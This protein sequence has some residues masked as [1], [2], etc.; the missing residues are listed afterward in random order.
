[1]TD[2][3]KLGALSALASAG[4]LDRR[5]FLLTA[6]AAGLSALAADAMWRKARAAEP[7]AGG[8]LSVGA[9]GGATSDTMSPLVATGADHPTIAALSCYDTL[10]EM[11]AAGTPQPSLAE[12][13]EGSADGTW[14]FRL[15]KGVEFHDGTPLTAA[16]VVWSLAQH[17]D[18]ASKFAEGKQIVGNFE[19][20]RAD[21]PDTVIIR[22]REVNFDLPAHLSS[23]GL[24]VGKEGTQTWDTGIG[25]G[26]YRLEAWEPGV[27]FAGRKFDGFYRDD[28]GH[29]DQ[30]EV[31]NVTD[32]TSRVGGLLSK[33]LDVIGSPP[34]ST[35]ARLASAPGV[36]LT[37]VA[38]TQH[39]TTDMR[40]DMDPFTSA[41]LRN[42]VKWGVKRDEI[43]QKVLGGYGTV[44]NDIPISRNQQ[45]HNDQLPQREYDPDKA[46]WHLRQAGMEGADLTF[47]TS[48]GAFTGAVDAGQLMQASM[49]P[50]GMNVTVKREPADG[51]WSNV[52][53]KAPWCAVYWNGRPT[54]D[55]MLT[56]TYH[57]SS[58][59]NSTYFNNAEFDR[60]L[61]AARGEPDEDTRRAMYFE[62][63]R[64]LW[65]EGGVVVLA[66]AN[67]LIAASDAMGHG[68]VGVSR[69]LDDSRITRRW[70]R[71]S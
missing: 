66:F 14:A 46:V 56:S 6:S 53:L 3:T 27:R 71:E 19:E 18:E 41:H 68:P 44:G 35:A 31:L 17:Q 64:L 50:L 65:E 49:A 7:K 20:L 58:D 62:A 69:R 61:G 26:P 15:R 21:G 60:L 9:D 40:T 30:V 4:R 55:W 32:P 52:W 34:T 63:Q 23:F 10:T 22:Q 5:R 16:D 48:D 39:F 70:W 2:P 25:T 12:S 43:V 59:W 67:I 51:Y 36:S 8:S 28:Q 33:S 38:A 57:S 1:M 54:V 37:E 47:H 42:A 13:W 11:D 24:I 29:F 45:F